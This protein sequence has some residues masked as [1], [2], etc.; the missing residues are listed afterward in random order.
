MPKLCG[1][2]KR[3]KR[4]QKRRDKD[5]R[6]IKERRLSRRDVD[7]LA[8]RITRK[9]VYVK[10]K[11]ANLKFYCKACK[12]YYCQGFNNVDVYCHECYYKNSCLKQTEKGKLCKICGGT[13]ERMYIQD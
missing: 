8:W 11:N 6:S 12:M 10:S 13:Y 4:K 2:E 7:K 3:K 9:V 5:T 1:A